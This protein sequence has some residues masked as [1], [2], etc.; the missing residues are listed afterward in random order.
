MLAPV[1]LMV[2]TSHWSGGSTR[3][4]ETNRH[5][6]CTS[7]KKTEKFPM[8]YARNKEVR[9]PSDDETNILEKKLL[10]MEEANV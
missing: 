5:V 3:W 10:G 1:V 4:I 6:H 7:W 8:M 2:A 9:K